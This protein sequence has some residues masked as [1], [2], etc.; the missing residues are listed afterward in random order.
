M[1]TI[2]PWMPQPKPPP[3]NDPFEGGGKIIDQVPDGQGNVLVT[4][5]LPDLST[6]IVR[7]PYSA[8]V[9]G[10]A[11]SLIPS[12]VEL[13]HSPSSDDADTGAADDDSYEQS[14]YK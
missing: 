9:A 5:A 3:P 10:D 11:H 4:Y 2:P 14:E 6:A 12:L 8:W 1:S 7:M 13:V